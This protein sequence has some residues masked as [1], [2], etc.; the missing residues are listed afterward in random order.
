MV[1]LNGTRLPFGSRRRSYLRN[2]SPLQCT[3]AKFR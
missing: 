3:V 1:P 2:I